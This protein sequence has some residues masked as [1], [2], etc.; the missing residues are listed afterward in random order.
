MHVRRKTYA[1]DLASLSRDVIREYEGRIALLESQNSR[2]SVELEQA[3]DALSDEREDRKIERHSLILTSSPP[4]ILP[5]PTELDGHINEQSELLYERRLRV[6][7]LETLKKI[8]AQNTTLSRE[9][10]EHKDGSASLTSILDAEREEKEQM[11]EEIT[12]LS[13]KNYTLFE[14]NKLLVGRDSALQEEIATLITKSQA[15]DW[16]RSVLEG[17]LRKARQDSPSTSTF[18]SSPTPEPPT[19]TLEHQGPLRCQLVAAQDELHITKLRLQTSEKKCQEFEERIA[20]LQQNMTLCLDS[21]SKALEVERGLR[22]ELAQHAANLEAENDSLKRDM[23]TTRF[24]LESLRQN[25]ISLGDDTNAIERLQSL[26]DENEQLK[27]QTDSMNLQLEQL[28]R[29]KKVD[30]RAD[31]LVSEN[32]DLKTRVT[33]L[34]MEL[35]GVRRRNSKVVTG[36]KPLRLSQ[37]AVCGVQKVTVGVRNVSTLHAVPEG[38]TDALDGDKDTKMLRRERLLDRQLRVAA[39]RVS[40]LY[41]SVYRYSNNFPVM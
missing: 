36:F 10:R 25:N 3:R 5:P 19:I 22:T 30:G 18:Q 29:R 8:R 23:E 35:D 37:G 21:S 39:S 7:I 26:E 31:A 11:R 41:C 38:T 20:G 40:G 14:H 16:M 6:E 34:E 13:Q 1:G 4:P 2:I 15:D 17:E 33:A 28:R 27:H 32:R 12:R 9:L 24:D